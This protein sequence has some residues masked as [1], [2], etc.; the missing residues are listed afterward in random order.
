[1]YFI[2]KKVNIRITLNFYESILIQ[3][4]LYEI[5]TF[6]L[7][8]GFFGEIYDSGDRCCRAVGKIGY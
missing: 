6:D 1:M 3:L 7:G 5:I 2:F 8:N 4:D